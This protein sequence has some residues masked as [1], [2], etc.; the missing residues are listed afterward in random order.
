MTIKGKRILVV[1]ASSD[2]ASSLNGML[3]EAGALVGLH[4]NSNVFALNEYKESRVVK[5]FQKNLDSSY[6]CHNLVD[7]F[8]AWSGGIDCLI[9]LS[10]DILEPVHWEKLNEKHWSYDLNANLLAPFFLSQRAVKYMK[11]AGGGRI[12]LMSTA[13]AAHGGGG[14]SMAYGV[15]KAGVE[16]MV[17]G[18]ARDC[19]KYN[20]LVNS[21]A[22]GFIKTKFHT[23]R[24]LRTDAQLEER[25]NLIPLK[26]AGTTEEIAGA[27]LFLLSEYSTYI[28][29]QVITVSGGDWL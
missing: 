27:I 5:K 28:T 18:L 19:A 29:G 17:K 8:V 1:G 22:P 16:C 12:I 13:S 26:R 25:M 15:S 2:M 24:M 6:S 21:I 3:I 11:D 23:K 4:Y 20:I 9:Q 14:S 10:G 7:E